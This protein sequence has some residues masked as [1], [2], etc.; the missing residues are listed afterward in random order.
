MNL[1][2]I[3]LLIYVILVLL[4]VYSDKNTSIYAYIFGKKQFFL[5][6]FHLPE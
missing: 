6:Y 3:G 2:D 1:H 5:I 4:Q